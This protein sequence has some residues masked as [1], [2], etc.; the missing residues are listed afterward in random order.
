MS[1]PYIIKLTPAQVRA[2]SR[3][4]Y[5]GTDTADDVKIDECGD[6]RPGCI[7]VSQG[8]ARAYVSTSG[9]IEE[10]RRP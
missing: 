6:S 7:Y 3:W 8:N 1:E 5:D 2:L 10:A 4:A 9:M